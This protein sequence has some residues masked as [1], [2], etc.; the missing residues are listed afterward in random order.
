MQE[1]KCPKSYKDSAVSLQP[2]TWWPMQPLLP[3]D[4][5]ASM[6]LLPANSPA[7]PCTQHSR[8]CRAPV[9][10]Q[11]ASAGKLLIYL[12]LTFFSQCLRQKI[13]TNQVGAYSRLQGESI[14]L[15]PAIKC[16]HMEQRLRPCLGA[17]APGF[18]AEDRSQRQKPSH[19][20]PQWPQRSPRQPD[21]FVW[22][23]WQARGSPHQAASGTT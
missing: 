9:P 10:V 20:Q 23:L 11:Q 7:P 5:A 18:T 3:S 1:Q 16:P 8:V 22:A 21:G 4:P 17:R 2:P 6:V 12:A 15:H 13:K 19:G 14:V